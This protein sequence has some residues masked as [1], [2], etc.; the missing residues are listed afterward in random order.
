MTPFQWL[1]LAALSLLLVREALRLGRGVGSRWFT[2]VR[3]AI[4]ASAAVT[5]YDPN[6]TQWVAEALGIGLGANLVL[7]V[8]VLAYLA[9]TFFLYARYLQ[10]QQQLTTVVRHLAL[11][12]AQKGQGET[13]P[14]GEGPV[15]PTS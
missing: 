15:A 10:M 14:E 12:E 4:W 5:I 1:T 6:L 9:T 7:Y 2:L 3:A 8:F 11:Q 13:A